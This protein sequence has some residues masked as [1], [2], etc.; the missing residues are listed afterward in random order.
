MLPTK[1]MVP[2]LAFRG[3][4]GGMGLEGTV[5]TRSVMAAALAHARV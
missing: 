4:F 1:R 3:E 5:H 2:C